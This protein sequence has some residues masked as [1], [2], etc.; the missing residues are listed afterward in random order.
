MLQKNFEF[1]NLSSVLVE[2]CFGYHKIQNFYGK[3]QKLLLKVQ[4][5]RQNVFFQLVRVNEGKFNFHFS[6]IEIKNGDNYMFI[7]KHVI[8]K[9]FNFLPKVHHYC[10]RVLL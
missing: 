10:Y 6:K 9:L 8:M 7:E 4:N 5:Y 3:I 1:Q 2:N